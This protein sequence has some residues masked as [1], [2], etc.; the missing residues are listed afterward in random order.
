MNWGN[1]LWLVQQGR[2][3]MVLSTK[4]AAGFGQVSCV[5]EIIYQDD[6]LMLGL[7]D[8]RT[9][10]AICI[11]QADEPLVR[12]VE[13]DTGN[14]PADALAL[15]VVCAAVDI[16][17]KAAAATREQVRFD[18]TAQLLASSE[19]RAILAPAVPV[20][21]TQQQSALEASQ[22]WLYTTAKRVAEEQGTG[23]LSS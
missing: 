3:L 21:L 2:K 8:G 4:I 11:R 20:D 5:L 7:F 9:A 23:R 16:S 1:E 17:A 10:L 19:T 6:F 13:L 12:V 22:V 18:L 15:S 14:K